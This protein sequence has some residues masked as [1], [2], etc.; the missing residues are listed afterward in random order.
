[1]T[2]SLRGHGSTV[3]VAALAAAFGVGLL[4]ATEV[5]SSVTPSGG[6]GETTRVMLTVVAL[7]FTAISIYVAAIVTTNTVATIVAGRVRTI[8]L[9]RLLGSSARSERSRIARE[10]L[11]AGAIGATI[12]AL[13]ALG[14]VAAF[15]AIG[16]ANGVLP[17]AGYAFV[18]GT[19]TIS[20]AAVIA[21]TWLAAW[22]GSRRVLAV[23]PIE[24]LGVAVPA[25]ATDIP[26]R[27]SR[28]AIAASLGGVG[29][30]LL[31]LAVV[32]GA[33]SPLAML[34]GL[35]GGV[36]TFTALMIGSV[37]IVPGLLRATGMIFGRSP[38]ATLGARNALRH[39]ERST[40]A[41]IGLV[42]GVA[43]V[44]MFVVAGMTAQDI[45]VAKAEAEWGT[46]APLDGTLG[47]IMAIMSSLVGYSAIIAAVGLVNTLTVGVLQRTR[48][49]GLVRALGLS[50]GQLH[51][52][53]SVEAVQLTL[54]AVV[55]G[56]TLGVLYGWV[57][58]VS[59]LGS[60]RPAFVTAPV[61]PWWLPVGLLVV[62]AMLSLV[63]SL[64]PARRAAAISPV[65]AIAVE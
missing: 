21:S 37:L 7:V 45:I 39:P 38:A 16:T 28:G 59:L 1:M 53:I 12:G 32:V 43:L 64:A 46:A 26:R 13:V 15:I 11:T 48:E 4:G 31:A 14:L 2:G 18:T 40:R 44:T 51:A 9:R 54:V 5:L 29:V 34:I 36:V 41:A 63:G 27:R 35:A 19:M 55:L 57:G 22:V 20:V 25:S 65:A 24:A 42:I 8:A 23:T 52:T 10:G 6:E 56:F 17:N 47:A 30:L 58:A 62:G 49:F 3:L 60:V 33:M 50:R 61:I